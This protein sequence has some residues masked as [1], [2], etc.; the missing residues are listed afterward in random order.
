IHWE[1]LQHPLL[2]PGR[3]AAMIKGETRIGFLGEVRPDHARNAGVEG[4]RL[5]VAELN[6]SILA[7]LPTSRS[8]GSITVD[9]YLPAD[10]DYAVIVDAATPAGD[11][12]A[13]L[14]NGAG[15][16]ATNV[17]LFDIFEGQQIGEGK[18]SLAYRVTFTAPDRALTDAELAKVRTKIE[19]VLKQRVGGQF[20]T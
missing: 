15:P 20:R 14:R 13:A 17:T 4:T 6:L 3:S 18:K 10:Q 7:A 16:L 8:R 9:R 1:P 2:H 19:K 5:V 11:V 12:E